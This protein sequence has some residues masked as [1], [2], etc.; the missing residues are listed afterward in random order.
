MNTNDL[1][2]DLSGALEDDINLSEVST[3]P[4]FNNVKDLKV[5]ASAEVGIT[6]MTIKQA[7]EITVGTVITL[8]KMEGE[9]AD[10][11][12]NNNQIGKGQIVLKDGRYG[13]KITHINE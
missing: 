10:F 12:I 7:E 5:V 13:I 2:L 3:T 6:N 8:D 1:D 4:A 9:L 11:K